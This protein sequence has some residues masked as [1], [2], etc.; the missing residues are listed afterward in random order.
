MDLFCIYLSTCWVVKNLE[1]NKVEEN[2]YCQHSFSVY[3]W[4]PSCRSFSTLTSML[5]YARQEARVKRH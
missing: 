5:I 2:K 1:R 3:W 4:L